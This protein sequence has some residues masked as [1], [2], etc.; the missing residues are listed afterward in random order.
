M[1][2]IL[3]I[4][5]LCV[6]VIAACSSNGTKATDD[7]TATLSQT[8]NE[9]RSLT[10]TL[11]ETSK[12]TNTSGNFQ[13]GKDLISKSDCISCH[14]DHE[15]LVGPAYAAVAAKYEATD[16]N[17]A[18]LVGKVISGGKGVWGEVPMTPHPA[19]SKDDATEMVKYVLSLK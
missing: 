3:I 13:K 4:I 18:M 15:K 10:D 16:T 6:S 2:K 12:A 9:N 19:L 17:I 1:K 8:N 5:G 14:K 11:G 7:T